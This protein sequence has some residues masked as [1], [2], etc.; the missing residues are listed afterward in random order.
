M[1][2]LKLWVAPFERL[3]VVL[4]WSKD[5]HVLFMYSWN[6]FCH[7]FWVL[8]CHVSSSNSTDSGYLVATTP[9]AVVK[10]SFL[11]FAGVF[12]MVSRYVCAF[13]IFLKLFLLVFLHF[14]FSHFLSSN[15]IESEYI[16]NATPLTVVSGSFWNFAGIFYMVWKCAY[17]LAINLRLIFVTIL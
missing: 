2:L 17:P 7:F 4:S 15:S 1:Q 9:P 11:N 8:N 5:V 16:V 3:Q 6:Y 10:C 13:G 12:V 14:R